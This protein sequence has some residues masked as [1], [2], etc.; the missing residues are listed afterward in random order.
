M[1]D[2]YRQLAIYVSMPTA[3]G[4]GLKVPPAL[5]AHADEV[6]ERTLGMD[7]S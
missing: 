1:P 5:L 7:V 2:T 3:R 6:I 4:L